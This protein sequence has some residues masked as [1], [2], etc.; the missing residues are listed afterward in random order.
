MESL[1]KISYIFLP[2]PSSREDEKGHGAESAVTDILEDCGPLF[3]QGQ[4]PA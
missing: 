3:R 2:A 4:T 1:N